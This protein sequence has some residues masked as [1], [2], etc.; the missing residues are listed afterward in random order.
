[1]T[2]ILILGAGAAGLSAGHYA[3]GAGKSV[4]ILEARNRAGGRIHTL[5]EAGFSFPVEAGAEFI[6]GDLPLTKGL[7][8]EARIEYYE[9]HGATWNVTNGK[10]QH[11]EFFEEGW[12]EFIE[13]LKELDHDMSIS[14]F[15]QQHFASSQYDF[16]R[17]SVI[18][19][20]QGYDAADA[21]KASA[22]A[23]REEWTSEDSMTGHRPKGGYSQMI[24]YLVDRC[25]AQGVTFHFNSVVKDITWK[26][27]LVEVTTH[28]GERYT[29]EKLLITIPVA[30]LRSGAVNFNPQPSEHL[31]ALHKIETG[32]VIKFLVEFQEAFWET[33][34]KP[35]FRAMPELHFLF[36]D[37]AIP[38][39][40]TQKPAPQPLLTGWLAGPAVKEHMLDDSVLI[41]EAIQSLAY[42][43]ACTP[44]ELEQQIKN[45]LVV[46]WIADP[47]SQGAYAYKTVDTQAALEILSIPVNNTLY[48]AGEAL[49]NGPAMGT[50][51]AALASGQESIKKI[52]AS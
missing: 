33:H 47:F 39:W 4:T 2:D 7:L 20:V 13:A 23:L 51:E 35:A 40:W 14:A 11:G 12:D 48:F 46:N 37:A 30:V 18:R 50:V 38:T 24:N 43:F 21:N 36:S 26:T 15:L 17:D 29:S 6:H 49:Y 28:S 10:L 19:F 32:G 1:M 44:A 52:L 31:A 5:H 25:K 34:Q 22:F 3:S 16:L 41:Q 42:C 8:E 9:G 45:I 27:G